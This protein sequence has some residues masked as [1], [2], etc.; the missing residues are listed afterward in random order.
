MLYALRHLITIY[1]HFR[2]KNSLYRISRPCISV[3]EYFPR[4]DYNYCGDPIENET[5]D[6]AALIGKD[7]KGMFGKSKLISG[8]NGKFY[9]GINDCS[10]K[11]EYYNT[12]EFS[13]VIKI[14]RGKK[15][16]IK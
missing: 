5:C 3:V 1:R 15:L 6:H 4:M 12:G 9:I 10:F 14:I 13:G 2:L 8:K 11:T 7:D 16:Q